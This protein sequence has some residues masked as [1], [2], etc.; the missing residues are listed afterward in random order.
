MHDIAEIKIF[1]KQRG[2]NP[3]AQRIQI[4]RILLS[5]F[6]HMSADQVLKAVNE[7]QTIVSKA[8]VYNTLNLFAEKGLVR[9]VIVDPNKVFY[10][11]N[12]SAHFHIYNEDSGQLIDLDA[13]KLEISEIPELPDNTV[14]C[15]VDV[16]I[17]IRNRQ[18]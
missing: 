10:D 13:G 17:R 2:I 1:M 18:L 9:Q 4:A 11:S 5:R 12:T 3:T 7:E 16:V 15:G 14:E 8:T 6:Q